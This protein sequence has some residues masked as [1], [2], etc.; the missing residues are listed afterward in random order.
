MILSVLR[1]AR[2]LGKWLL[3]PWIYLALQFTAR[4]IKLLPNEHIGG[5]VFARQGYHL[6]RKYYGAPI[7]DESDLTGAFWDQAS[8]MVGLHMNDQTALDLLDTVI[9]R[10]LDEFRNCFPN[11]RTSDPKMFYLLNSNYM[12]VDAHVYYSMIRHFQPKRIIEIGAGNS[13]VLAAAAGQQNQVETGRAPHLIA[14]EPYP[15]SF[16]KEGFPGLSQLISEKVQDVT[17]ECFKSLGAG[18]ILFIDSSHVLRSGGDVQYEYLEI[19]PRLNPGVLIH[20]HDISLPKPY[21][22]VYFEQQQ[23]W[24][25]QY[26]LQAFLAFNSRFEVL[27]AGNYM[28]IRYPQK[29]DEVFPELALMRQ[30]FPDAHPSAFWMRAR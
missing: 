28:A 19:L 21:P 25:E 8:E 12:A 26:L 2:R 1:F 13:T 15:R 16:V 24:N 29:I 23:Y 17:L 22:R 9:R 3:W 14:I 11:H 27:W 7:P 10:Y 20:I 30:N 4:A 5:K 18:D 6:L